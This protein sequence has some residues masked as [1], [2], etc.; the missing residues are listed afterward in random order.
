VPGVGNLAITAV[1]TRDFPKIQ[2]LV[3]I[4]GLFIVVANLVVDLLYGWVNPRGRT[5]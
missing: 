5:P 2:G 1:Q 3:V 4:V